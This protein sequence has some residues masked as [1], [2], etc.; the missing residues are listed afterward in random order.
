MRSY[1]INISIL[2]TKNL[3]LFKVNCERDKSISGEVDTANLVRTR[4]IENQN[5][6]YVCLSDETKQV[7][8]V[9]LRKP[10]ITINYSVVALMS[11]LFVNLLVT[12]VLLQHGMIRFDVLPRSVSR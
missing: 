4:S 8:R 3:A 6:G 9:A 12:I 5:T 7:V 1:Y 11:F 10:T 2:M